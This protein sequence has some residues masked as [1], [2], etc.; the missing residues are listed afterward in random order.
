VDVIEILAFN[1]QTLECKS[2]A[3]TH[4][5]TRAGTS[6]AYVAHLSRAPA[7]ARACEA[8]APRRDLRVDDDGFLNSCGHENCLSQPSLQ[9]L[10]SSFFS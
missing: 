10:F 7:H 3:T 8:M 9:L 1:K 5:I 4:Q 6:H 2:F